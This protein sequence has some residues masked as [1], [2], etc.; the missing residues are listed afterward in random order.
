[1]Q[2]NKLADRDF[3][4][5]GIA[6]DAANRAV[7]AWRSKEINSN[8]Y[9]Q[10]LTLAGVPQWA[11]DLQVNIDAT[12]S[13]LGDYDVIDEPVI[14]TNASSGIAVSWFSYDA[15]APTNISLRAQLLTA[16]GSRSWLSE[17]VIG[18]P[19]DEDNLQSFNSPCF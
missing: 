15:D 19:L 12:N 2:A 18:I 7:I 3:F 11:S 8:V 5:P 10:R 16:D 17:P 4:K 13:P 1:M 6:I 9:A 14:K